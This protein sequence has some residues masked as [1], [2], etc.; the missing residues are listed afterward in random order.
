M[1]WTLLLI[2]ILILL[3]A[4]L[5][6]KKHKEFNCIACNY[7]SKKEFKKCPICGFTRK[8]NI[9]GTKGGSGGGYDG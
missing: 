7:Q 2:V 4:Y 6:S 1:K 9:G 8:G 3:L 5:F